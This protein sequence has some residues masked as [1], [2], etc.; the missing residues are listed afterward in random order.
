MRRFRGPI[1]LSGARALLASAAA[2]ALSACATGQGMFVSG[3]DGGSSDQ[4]F[5][6]EE[7]FGEDVAEEGF[8]ASNDYILVASGNVLLPYPTG[9]GPSRA[10]PA[11][12]GL[13][14][15]VN[16][17]TQPSG[18]AVTASTPVA[19]LGAQLATNLPAGQVGLEAGA[20]ATLP[21]AQAT[22]GLGL[23]T[24]LAAGQ[25]ALG[26]GANAN[27]A[28]APLGANTAL[29]LNAPAGQAG[30]SAGLATPVGP[31][32]AGLQIGVPLT[33]ASGP[34]VST[35]AI[36]SA[37]RVGVGLVTPS[38]IQA[39]QPLITLAGSALGGGV[40]PGAQ[41]GPRSSPGGN[42]NTVAGANVTNLADAVMQM[43]SPA[44]GATP[45][46]MSSVPSSQVLGGLVGLLR[47]PG[48]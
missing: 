11:G 3:S 42:P 29:A 27:L 24:N 38:L 43:K 33:A 39:G 14:G 10:G 34:G 36:A 9:F 17:L 40:S 16:G 22:A 21:G 19:G 7:G 46:P 47:P 48:V 5:A 4:A 28:G 1:G 25:T 32:G 26:L 30:A 45:A 2:L 35:P 6:E 18:L 8:A 12:P 23:S 44:G 15:A 31:L 37:P 13:V 41:A 20:Q